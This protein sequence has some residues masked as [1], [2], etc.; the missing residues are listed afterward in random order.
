MIELE[1]YRSR[2]GTFSHRIFSNGRL[3]SRDLRKFT[4]CQNTSRIKALSGLKAFVKTLLVAGIVIHCGIYTPGPGLAPDYLQL[5]LHDI[6]YHPGGLLAKPVSPWSRTLPSNLSQV[7]MAAAED[8]NFL[9]RYTYGNKKGTGIKIAHWN[10]GPSFLENKKD[11]VETLIEKYQPH[12]IGLSEANLFSHHDV[13]KVQYQDYNLHTCPTINNPELL[14]SRVVVYTHKSLVVKVRHDLMDSSVSA[15]WL[16]VGLPNRRKILV[17]NMYREWG[18]LRQQDK[19]SHTIAAQLIRW[20]TLL[21]S[22]EKALIEDKEV[23]VVGDINIDSLKW[24]RDDL[25]SNDSTRKLKPLIDLLFEKIIPHGVSQ[26]VNTAT[27]SWA[28]Q[29]GSCLDHVYTNRPDKLSLVEAHV[30]G[31][32]DHRVLYT[33]RYAKSMKKNIRYV[34]KRCFK[35]FDV[36]GFKQEVKQIKWFDVYST[37]D[38]NDAVRV[39]TGKLTSVLD[40]FAPVKTIQVRG[41]YAPW[42]TPQVKAK[43]SERD[44]AQL[45]ASATQCQDD[46]RQ[47]R[48]LRNSVTTLI[49]R[50][51]KTWE[52]QQLDSFSSDATNMWRNVKGWMGW[53]NSGP[54]TQL[55]SRGKIVNSPSGLATEMNDFF[56]HKVQ[57]LL[58]KL[59]GPTTDPLENL[60]RLME[61]RTC[62]FSFQPVHPDEVLEIVMRMRNSKST[63]LDNIDT[64]SIKLIISDVLPALTHVVNLSLSTLVFPSTWKQAKVIPLLKKGDPLDPSN[65]RPVALLSI[66]SKI[67]ERVVFKQV[68]VYMENNQ[69]LH[70]SHHGSRA[71]HSTCTAL[72][73]MY[74]NWVNSMERDEMTG[75]MMLDLSAAFDLVDHS[76]LLKKMELLGFDKEVVVWF[77]TYLSGRS[78]CVYVDGKLS[79][80]RPVPVG[81]PQGSVLGALLYILFV[82]DLPEVVHGHDVNN[83]GQDERGVMYNLTC[84]GCGSLCCYVDDSTYSYS[85]PS[86]A[87]LSE[88]LS[89]Q[90]RKIAD[91]M[92]ANRLVINDDK[93]HLLVMGTKKHDKVRSEVHID[94]G[95][96]VVSPSET[97]KLLGINI[98]QSMKWKE[99]LISNEKSMIKMLRTRLNALAIIATRANFKTR[100]MVA[101]ACFMSI[102]TYMVAV[103]GGTEEYIIKAVQVMQNKAARTVTRLTWYTPTRKLLQQCNWLS[104]KQLIFFHTVLLVWRVKKSEQPVYIKSKFQPSR[105]RTADQGN[106]WLP[107]VQYTLSRKSFMIRSA[108]SWNSIPPDI[109]NS[110]T[111]GTFKK[112]LK[113]WTKL[114]IDID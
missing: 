74:D 102:I 78:Q 112:K 85:S 81:V 63:G 67:M 70:P 76:L 105:T 58:Q 23:I 45:K 43:M 114:N 94:T 21:N 16:E 4:K 59:P 61:T 12:I 106:F 109:R 26:H 108:S 110:N 40:K 25:P 53:K 83:L 9:A 56:I 60:T 68:V 35:N 79:E 14:V 8:K 80:S 77:W 88:K 27:H 2:I 17:C 104:V 31:G 24:C 51:K 33:V 97:Q 22:W 71:N 46:W 3:A 10:K 84:S 91:Y 48:N 29:E 107:G 30:N 101:N 49:K 75:V 62:S 13:S 93:T 28:G 82:N 15:V 111:I 90:Y 5:V 92:S 65:Y 50:D 36:E 72:I 7:K 54:P 11:D 113:E 95:T 41:R 42:I 20:K 89:A 100:L 87:I 86:S 38:V 69:L 64:A 73:E 37:N 66:L 57:R 18:Y 19:S 96:V 47:Y 52:A 39:L 55:F 34:K 103:W 44:R 1:Q 99:H 6:N 98:H 32:S